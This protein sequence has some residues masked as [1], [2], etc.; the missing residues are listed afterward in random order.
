MGK[1]LSFAIAWLAAVL[2]VVW[3]GSAPDPYMEHVRRIPAPHQYPLRG[4]ATALI[5]LTIQC[6]LLF[7]VLRPW[8]FHMPRLRVLLALAIALV[9]LALSAPGFHSPPYLAA[10]AAWQLS[11]MLLLFIFLVF[12]IV[13][14]RVARSP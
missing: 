13:R 3:S 5:L 11:V 7:F 4:V 6:A 12:G 9:F 1:T 14:R 2:A 10:L 8:S